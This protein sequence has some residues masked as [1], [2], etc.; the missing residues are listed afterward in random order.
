[1]CRFIDNLKFLIKKSLLSPFINAAEL[2]AAKILWV[3]ENQKC[4]DNKKL[5][6]LTKDINLIL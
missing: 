5:Y 6:S 1:M 3:K 4:F 2:T